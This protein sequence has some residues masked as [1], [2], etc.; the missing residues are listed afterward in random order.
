MSLFLATLAVA[1]GKTDPVDTSVWRNPDN[2]IPERVKALVC[3]LTMKEKISLCYWLSPAIDRLGIPEYD[4]GN[5]C[6]HGLVRPG[7]NTVFPAAIGLGATF[8]PDLAL[9]EATAISDEARVRFNLA[10]GKSLGK[11]NDVLTLW[12]PVV[13]MARDPRWGRT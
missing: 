12:S 4:H 9:R 3:Q 2:P 6:L 5:E 13:N 7:K 1:Q 8:D 11:T 10:G